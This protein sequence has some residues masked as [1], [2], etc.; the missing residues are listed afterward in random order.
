M[1][2]VHP[3]LAALARAAA[4]QD[5]EEMENALVVALRRREWLRP[6]HRVGDPTAYMR[7]VLYVDPSD[8]FVMTAITWLPGQVSTVHGHHVWC[9]YGVAEG[10][11][12]EER[13]DVKK[14]T[15]LR[16]GE[17]ADRDLDCKLVHRVANRSDRSIVSLHLYGISAARLTTGINRIVS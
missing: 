12:T 8:Q 6:E 3:A 1:S 2:P 4:S 9:A 16:A 15:V 13:F 7:H 11:L 17:M 14:T 5:F 10:E